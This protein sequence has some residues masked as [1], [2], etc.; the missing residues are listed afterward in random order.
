MEQ[1]KSIQNNN[2][3]LPGDL[4]QVKMGDKTLNI[5]KMQSNNNGFITFTLRPQKEPSPDVFTD[6]EIVEPLQ[7]EDKK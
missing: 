6:Y 5:I 4:G 3:Y 2:I 1:E 7:I